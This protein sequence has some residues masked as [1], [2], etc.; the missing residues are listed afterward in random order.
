M[1]L[2]VNAI[3]RKVQ[4]EKRK[5]CF[6]VT[7]TNKKISVSPG[8]SE[9][10]GHHGHHGHHHEH[11]EHRGPQFEGPR[12]YGRGPR[13]GGPRGQWGGPQFEGPRGPGVVASAVDLADLV[14][15]AAPEFNR[16]GKLYAAPLVK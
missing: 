14:A 6:K 11:H 9:H 4:K 12:G 16:N 8:E 3:Y 1:L 2:R 13:F 10:H 7:T 15:M 5:I